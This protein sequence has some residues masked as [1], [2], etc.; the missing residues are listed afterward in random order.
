M[1]FYNTN[2]SENYGFRGFECVLYTFLDVFSQHLTKPLYILSLSEL[3]KGL[4]LD[5]CQKSL[6]NVREKK[7]FRLLKY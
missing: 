1:M 4:D 2:E 3:K 5:K 6:K 7:N